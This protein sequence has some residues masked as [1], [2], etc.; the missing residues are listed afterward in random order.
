VTDDDDATLII[1]AL[2]DIRTELR[3]IRRLLEEDCGGEPG[4]EEEEP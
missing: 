4:R 1:Q 2:F 3:E